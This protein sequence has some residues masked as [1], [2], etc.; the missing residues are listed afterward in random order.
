M[1]RSSVQPAEH[2]ARDLR[3]ARRQRRRCPGV[4][5]R[6]APTG[7]G[8]DTIEA[9]DLFLRDRGLRFDAVVIGGTALSLLGVVSRPTKDIDILVPEIP[10]EIHIAARAWKTNGK[11][12]K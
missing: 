3:R 10:Q 2:N 8:L 6:K 1:L 4:S 12:G 9:F 5:P 7:R 11:N